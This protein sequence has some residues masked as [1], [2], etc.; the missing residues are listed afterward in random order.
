MRMLARESRSPGQTWCPPRLARLLFCTGLRL[1]TARVLDEYES[2][3]KEHLEAHV[4]SSFQRLRARACAAVS[5]RL[6]AS[7]NGWL[8][9]MFST[10]DVFFLGTRFAYAIYCK[11]YIEVRLV[12][13]LHALLNHAARAGLRN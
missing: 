13:A 12:R 7:P 5:D 8:Q 1:G 6:L 3:W 10:G 2:H 11:R 4:P 9:G